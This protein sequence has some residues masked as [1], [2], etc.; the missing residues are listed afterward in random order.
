MPAPSPP[1]GWVASLGLPGWAASMISSLGIYFV[2]VPLL[3]LVIRR[4]QRTGAPFP[5]DHTASAKWKRFCV[6]GPNAG[7]SE[8]AT[9][10]DG[11]DDAPG[12]ASKRNSHPTPV[13]SRE[14]P[15]STGMRALRLAFCAGGLLSS[16][17]IWGALQEKILTYEYKTGKWESSTFLVFC[18]RMVALLVAI[19]VHYVF[20]QPKLQSPFYKYSLVSLSNVMSSWCQLEALKYVSF[21]TQVLT[22]SSKLIPVMLMGKAISGKKYP[23]YEYGV[24]IVIAAGV[25]TFMLSEKKEKMEDNPGLKIGV[26]GLFLLGGYLTFD[27]FTSQWQGHLFTTYKM[28]SYQMMMG[29]NAFSSAFTL[30]SLLFTGELFSSLKFLADNPQSMV[31]ILGFSC[32]GATGQMFIY[33]TIKTLGPLVFTMIMTTRQLMAILLSCFLYGHRIDSQGVVG[34]VIVF[35]AIGYRIYRK[36]QDRRA[37]KMAARRDDNSDQVE[38]SP[39]VRKQ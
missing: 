25:A 19:G 23:W 18:N 14:R 39:I 11:G 32:A 24:A 34:A 37:K 35:T 15:L 27:S 16:Y 10:A 5:D 2:I 29:I 17:L 4:I 21:P 28:T 12:S 38:I 8:V 9:D 31:H 26:A 22:K 20:I 36:E 3:F 13:E 6:F 30:L 1:S 33:Y 7:Y